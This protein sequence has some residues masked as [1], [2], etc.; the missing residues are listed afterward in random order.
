MNEPCSKIKHRSKIVVVFILLTG[1]IPLIV[2]YSPLYSPLAQVIVGGLISS[3]LLS[4][5]LTPVLYK[6]LPPKI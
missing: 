1:M 3:L 6:L 4:R 2:Q 5:V